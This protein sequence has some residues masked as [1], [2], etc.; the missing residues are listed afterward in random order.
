MLVKIDVSSEV[1]S[2][3]VLG[4]TEFG[5]IGEQW[6]SLGGGIIVDTK[7]SQNFFKKTWRNCK[8]L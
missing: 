4:K 3:A 2:V 5:A 6:N 8:T 1:T 7:D